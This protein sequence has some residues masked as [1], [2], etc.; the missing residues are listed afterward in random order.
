MERRL[1]KRV[2]ALRVEKRK[3][4]TEMGRLYEERFGGSGRRVENAIAN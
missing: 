3:N 2:D 4:V 1:M